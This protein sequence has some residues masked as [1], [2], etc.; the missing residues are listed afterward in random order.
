M[1]QFRHFSIEIEKGVTVVRLQDPRL[2]D[3]LLVSE[4][5][6]ELLRLIDTESP[7][8]LLVDFEAVDHCSTAVINGLLR[9]KK[10]L[11][12]THGQI[13]LCSMHSA[14]REAYR[15][16][17]L[18]GTVFKIYDNTTRGITALNL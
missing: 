9:A 13:G 2:A 4:L 18:D 17:N 15:V 8:K 5:E 11:V 7:E 1:A 16:L 6:D 10:R 3:T 14:I 12:R